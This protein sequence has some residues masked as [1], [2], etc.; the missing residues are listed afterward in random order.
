MS[1]LLSLVPVLLLVAA[2]ALGRYPGEGALERVRATRRRRRRPA[3]AAS[4]ARS[5]LTLV[6]GGLL[7]AASLAGRAPPLA[8][9]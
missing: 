6:R 1:V 2:L 8:A 5:P 9:A 4:P 7:V 3:D